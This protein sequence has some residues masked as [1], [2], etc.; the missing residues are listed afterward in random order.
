[1]GRLRRRGWAH[2]LMLSLTHPSTPYNHSLFLP[3][4]LR[5]FSLTKMHFIASLLL[6]HCYIPIVIMSEFVNRFG[7]P[8]AKKALVL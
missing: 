2:S 6:L 7:K 3:L 1:M 8:F 4:V 5:H